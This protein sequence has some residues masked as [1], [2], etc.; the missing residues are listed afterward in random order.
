MTKP[1]TWVE[2]AF[3]V[4]KHYRRAAGIFCFLGVIAGCVLCSIVM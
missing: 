3:T 2:E 1:E 4:F